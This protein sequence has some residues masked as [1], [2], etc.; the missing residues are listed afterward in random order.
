MWKVF[1]K[2]WLTTHIE[3]EYAGF[4]N[5]L[6]CKHPQNKS[7]SNVLGKAFL[8]NRTPIVGAIFFG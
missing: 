3:R 4:T 1:T 6:H 7:I 5:S 8:N 2:K